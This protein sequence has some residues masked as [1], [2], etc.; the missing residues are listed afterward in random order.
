[1]NKGVTIDYNNRVSLVMLSNLMM[2]LSQLG[3]HLHIKSWPSRPGNTRWKCAN[4]GSAQKNHRTG[5]YF[6]ALCDTHKSTIKVIIG[7]SGF[8]IYLIIG[9]SSLG[10]RAAQI[11]QITSTISPSIVLQRRTPFEWYSVFSDRGVAPLISACMNVAIITS[12]CFFKNPKPKK[13]CS[14]CGRSACCHRLYS[15]CGL[16]YSQGLYPLAAWIMPESKIQ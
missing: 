13:P 10:V 5:I 3:Q 4:I 6:A 2:P 9:W 7:R 1:M 14:V 12:K 16:L 15:W 11:R 8:A